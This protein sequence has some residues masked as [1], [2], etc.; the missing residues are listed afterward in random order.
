MT[1]DM[2]LICSLVS[3]A[4]LWVFFFWIYRDYSIECFRQKVFALRDELF[5]TAASGEMP[6]NHRSYGRLR[7]TMNGAIRFANEIS[8]IQ[9]IVMSFLNRNSSVLIDHKRDFEKEISGL[10]NEQRQIIK[11]YYDRFDVLLVEHIFISS[12][13]VWL[14]F[15]PPLV[16][17]SLKLLSAWLKRKIG[18]WCTES[19]KIPLDEM[20]SLAYAVGSD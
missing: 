11:N 20:R 6:F 3:V 18:R 19:F 1:K 7:L 13:V 4:F 9:I 14:M 12:P 16:Y 15:V 10:T 8:F 5:E 2:N 17:F